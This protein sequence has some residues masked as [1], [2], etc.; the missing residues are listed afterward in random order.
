MQQTAPDTIDRD[1]LVALMD[2][3]EQD[4]LRQ[5]R[6]ERGSKPYRPVNVYASKRRRC[7]RAMALDMLHPEDDPFD[8]PIQF[9]R[10]TQG[11]EAERAIIARLHSIGPF[12]NPRFTIAEQ[13]HRFEVN[14]RQD[15]DGK[16][17]PVLITGKMDGRAR[18]D[19]GDRPPFEIKSGKT[20]ENC[21]TVEDLDRSVWA[22]SAVDQLLSYLFADLP[23]NYANREPWGF[24]FI[25]RQSRLPVAIRIRLLDH[26]QRVEAFM[27]DARV[28]VDARHGR[29]ELPTFTQ[30]RGECRRCPHLGKS[31]TPPM[32]F[33][34]GTQVIT[35]AAMID[36]AQTR[37]R[38]RGAYEQYKAADKYLK[39]SLRGTE[40]AILGP[41]QVMGKWA[42][43]TSY[44]VPKAIKDEYRS[45][46]EKG[47]FTLTI[48]RIE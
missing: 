37:E 44:D 21:E 13:Q 26:L 30:D 47:R 46:K 16:E 22:R 7:V 24:L 32:D 43:S 31:C 41:Y 20:Y 36:A 3:W 8:K 9:E 34:P 28:A 48:E 35:D 39:D 11:N 10:M 27:K 17:G 14:D 45:V 6:R 2:A 4:L 33:G 1:P 12:C 15:P 18:F 23:E 29:G 5:K 42:P 25:R 40:M 38:H 19:N